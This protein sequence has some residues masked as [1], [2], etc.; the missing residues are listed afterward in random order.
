MPWSSASR[1]TMLSRRIVPGLPFLVVA[2]ACA[3]TH[4]RSFCRA[5]SSA[6]TLLC[7]LL[8]ICRLIVG[9]S[10]I[11][12]WTRLLVFSSPGAADSA[13]SIRSLSCSRVVRR[14][15]VCLCRNRRTSVSAPPV[16]QSAR[17]RLV[18]P[19]SRGRPAGAVCPRRREPHT[20]QAAAGHRRKSLRCSPFLIPPAARRRR[21]GPVRQSRAPPSPTASPPR[22]P[23]YRPDR[24]PWPP[25]PASATRRGG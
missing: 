25:P 23:R 5:V 24:T 22:L 2:L 7:A 11:G 18:I 20:T 21:C 9:R 15:C 13:P 14:N 6:M 17:R 1:A 12:R 10:M 8:A 16:T 3:M 4:S 19:V